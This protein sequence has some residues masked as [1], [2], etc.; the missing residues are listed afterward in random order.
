M[1]KI[2]IISKYEKTTIN[3]T[4]GNKAVRKIY[5]NEYCC[6]FHFFLSNFSL[7]IPLRKWPITVHAMY[8]SWSRSFSKTHS[9]CERMWAG[10][11]STTPQF[12]PSEQFL[13]S[14]CC[15][16]G[17]LNHSAT[18]PPLCLSQI[19][20]RCNV[21]NRYRCS[22]YIRLSWHSLTTTKRSTNALS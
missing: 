5:K 19:S 8:E 1:K 3:K 10:T 18:P 7:L 17:P 21:L 16:K 14:H 20:G 22:V 12:M 9:L 2:I 13:N 4:A 15:H 11:T 6:F